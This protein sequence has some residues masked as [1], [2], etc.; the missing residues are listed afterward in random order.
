MSKRSTTDMLNECSP[1][2][3]ADIDSGKLVLRKRERGRILQPKQRV[4]IYLDQAVIQHFKKLAGAR[5]YQTL[6]NEALKNA[7]DQEKLEA[8]LRKVIRQELKGDKRAA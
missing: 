8:T 2:R 4:N 3:Q 5:G 6:I 1:I 7:I